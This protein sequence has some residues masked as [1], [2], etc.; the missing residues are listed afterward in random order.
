MPYFCICVH[1]CSAYQKND[2]IVN[3]KNHGSL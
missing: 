3:N 1:K 2:N